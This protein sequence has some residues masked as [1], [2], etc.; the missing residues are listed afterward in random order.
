MIAIAGCPKNHIDSKRFMF[1]W[2]K[3]SQVIVMEEDLLVSRHY[4]KTLLNLYHWAKKSYSNIEPYSYGPIA[5]ILKKQN[6]NA[7]DMSV[8]PGRGGV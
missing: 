4:F 2:C 5:K 7:S 1:D 3:F 8:K 6:K